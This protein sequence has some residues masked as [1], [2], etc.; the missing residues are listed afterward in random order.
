MRGRKRAK[1]MRLEPSLHMIEFSLKSCQVIFS[2]SLNGERGVIFNS[3]VKISVFPDISN[4]FRFYNSAEKFM[5]LSTKEEIETKSKQVGVILDEN[6]EM[7]NRKLRISLFT[8]AKI[9][10]CSKN[11]KYISNIR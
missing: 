1:K 8:V 6:S 2:S 7:L 9:T 5:F 11:E 10:F 3:R 4:Y